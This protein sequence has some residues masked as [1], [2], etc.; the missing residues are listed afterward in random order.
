MVILSYRNVPPWYTALQKFEKYD[1]FCAH[2]TL[3]TIWKHKYE[4]N[5]ALFLAAW[6]HS[7]QKPA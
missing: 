7:G 6:Q 3:R 5:I 2:N 4:G 1:C